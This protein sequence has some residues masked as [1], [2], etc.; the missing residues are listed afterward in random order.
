MPE[1]LLSLFFQLFVYIV[2]LFFLIAFA[3]LVK[4]YFKNKEVDDLPYEEVD[5]LPYKRAD[6]V[7][8]LAEQK[9]FR[10]LEQEFGQN[11]Y[12][13]PQV[14]LDK[15]V[16]TTDQKNFYTYWNKIN[17]KSVDFVL[18]DK[19]TLQTVQLIELND[20][21]HNQAKRRQRDEFLRRICEKA[22]IP[23]KMV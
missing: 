14:K 12:V 13:F 16:N 1:A 22:G 23:L 5:S 17:K 10:Q 8:T 18:V 19:Q 6:C 2:L 9:Y 20:Y 7:M 21:S 4:A 3:K 11:H 15:I